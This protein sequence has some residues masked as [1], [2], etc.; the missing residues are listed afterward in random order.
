MSIEKRIEIFRKQY[1][2]IK[3]SN[4]MIK[5]LIQDIKR[6]KIRLYKKGD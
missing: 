2:E 1:P 3:A 5:I 6:G 4:T